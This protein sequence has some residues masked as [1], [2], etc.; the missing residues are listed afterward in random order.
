MLCVTLRKFVTDDAFISVRYADNIANGYGFVWSPHG[1]PVEGF[2]N[3]LLVAI[4]A[5]ARVLGI[6]AIT[7]TR[8]VG[9]GSGVTL[10]VVIAAYAPRVVGRAASAIALALVALYPPLA[11]WAVGGLET[12][13]A[14]LVVTSGILVLCREPTRRRA[15]M[16]GCVFA[17]LPWLRPEGI[18]VALAAA[19]LAELPR[20]RS[21]G[22][23]RE[24]GARLALS[25]GIPLSSQLLLELARLDVYGHL[26]PNS[27]IF[28]SG[29]GGTF[30]VL[31]R[32]AA[33]GGPVILAAT[34]GAV[35]ARGRARLLA[36]PPLAYAAGSV[37]MSDQVNV[38]SRFLLPAWPALALL[39]GA[40]LV[41]VADRL[42]RARWPVALAAAGALVCG[43][44]IVLP[45]R[46]ADAT[47]YADSYAACPQRAR[48]EAVKWLRAHTWADTAYSVSDAGLMAAGSGP[49]T[50]IDQ[51]GL[52]TAEVQRTGPLSY[53]ARAAFVLD[54]RP[55][56][57]VLVSGRRWSLSPRYATDGAIAADPRFSAYSLGHVA[58][59]DW[60]CH[61]QLFIYRRRAT[62]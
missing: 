53:V 17:V 4:E 46:L 11:L 27:V 26:L 44:L 12:L 58:R 51:L 35:V 59:V 8:V 60:R 32:F 30:D 37:G 13:P 45:G 6:G 5:L 3:P 24:A 56:E 14:A 52:N 55:D 7:A 42:G 20:L 34:A 2:S 21:P 49:R 23:R 50:V 54:R 22:G 15:A 19:G 41:A 47:S 62:T 18:A 61:Y 39:A 29:A 9:I 1:P 28:K 25:G 57:I 48:T 10:L 40:A 31:G 43:G 38:F 33:Q 16:A 36:V